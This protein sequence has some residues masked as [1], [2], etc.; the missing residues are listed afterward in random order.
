MILA[1]ALIA[2]IGA[3]AAVLGVLGILG[4]P[5]EPLISEKLTWQ[6]WFALSGIFFL[7]SIAISQ[8]RRNKI[9]D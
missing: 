2:A 4:I 6:F 8:L 5:S 9:E 3:I 7:A 1:A